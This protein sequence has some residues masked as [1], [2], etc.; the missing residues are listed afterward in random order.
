MIFVVL[1][2]TLCLAITLVGI[3]AAAETS[4]FSLSSLQVKAFK[5]DSDK[6]KQLVGNLLSKPR[7]LLVTI[8]MVNIAMNILVQNIIASIFGDYEAWW[9]NVLIPLVLTL[10]FGEVIPKSIALSNNIKIAMKIAPFILSMQWLLG[11]IRSVLNAITQPISRFFFFFLKKEPEISIEELKHAL[12]TSEQHEILSV[13]ESR[14]IYG[15]LELEE[16]LVKEVMTPRTSMH[17]YSIQDPIDVLKNLILTEGLSRIPVYD[18]D[19]DQVLGIL[20]AELLVSLDEKLVTGKQVLPFLRKPFFV[21]ESM[22]AKTLFTQFYAEKKSL[23]IVVDEYGVIAGLVTKEDLVKRLIGE[24]DAEKEQLY[25]KAAN[26]VIIASSTMELSD[27]NELF[28]VNLESDSNMAT[29]GGWLIE[30]LGEIPKSG[31]KVQKEG[32]FFHVLSASP[33]KIK[34]LYIR[35]SLEKKE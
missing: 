1:I 21:P 14:L 35:K 18:K 5:D 30:K 10:L 17:I 12:K 13:G 2:I 4:L 34:T 6:K 32:F 3:L 19:R 15:Y 9:L 24:S 23:A 11:P 25:T 22:P 31:T 28:H 29:I 27:F 16:F 33:R 26:D 7:D 20:K 8:L